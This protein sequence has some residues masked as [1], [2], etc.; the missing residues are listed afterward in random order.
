VLYQA[1]PRPDTIEPAHAEPAVG[2]T[3]SLHQQGLAR[4]R[5]FNICPEIRRRIRPTSDS[6]YSLFPI[7]YSSVP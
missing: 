5:R 7:P 6:A 1:E 4:L 2:V 3:I